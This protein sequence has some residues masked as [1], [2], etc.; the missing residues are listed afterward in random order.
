[1][2][3]NEEIGSLTILGE[4]EEALNKYDGDQE[5]FIGLSKSTF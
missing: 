5:Y 2:F 3:N 1:M 4:L